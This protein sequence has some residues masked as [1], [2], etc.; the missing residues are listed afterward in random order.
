[1]SSSD[2]LKA[3]ME[4]MKSQLNDAGAAMQVLQAQA[5]QFRLI[6]GVLVRRLGAATATSAELKKTIAESVAGAPLVGSP[7]DWD[8]KS[9][10]HAEAIIADADLQSMGAA[11]LMVTFKEQV[12]VGDDGQPLAGVPPRLRVVV[13]PESEH[14][15]EQAANAPRIVVP[16]AVVP[17]LPNPSGNG[18]SG[19]Q[20]HARTPAGLILASR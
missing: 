6:L 19:P 11:R 14:A 4:M 16:E 15:A 5:A 10:T 8:E 20:G 7:P 18:A 12:A 2:R 9:V 17:G 13:L 1:M 3:E